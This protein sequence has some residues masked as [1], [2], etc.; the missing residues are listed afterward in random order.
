MASEQFIK[1]TSSH[2]IKLIRQLF[3]QFVQTQ[4]QVLLP[5][6]FGRGSLRWI[7]QIYT[8]HAVGVPNGSPL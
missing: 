4:A 2:R 8:S 5:S 7:G 3:Y 6:P 1:N